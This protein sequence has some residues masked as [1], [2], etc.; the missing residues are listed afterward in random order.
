MDGALLSLMNF[1]YRMNV[2]V[3]WLLEKGEGYGG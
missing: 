2:I 3:L 1:L